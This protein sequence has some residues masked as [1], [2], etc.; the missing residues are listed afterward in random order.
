MHESLYVLKMKMKIT[1]LLLIFLPNIVLAATWCELDNFTVDTYD[2]GGTYIKGTLNSKG[3]YVKNVSYVS[4]KG[5]T[6][7]ITNRRTSVSLAA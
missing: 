6:E 1:I 7:G 3:V 4:L 2:H 5:N